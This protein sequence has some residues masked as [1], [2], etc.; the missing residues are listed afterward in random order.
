[1]ILNPVQA[2]ALAGEA[3]P[4][5]PRTRSKASEAWGLE[6]MYII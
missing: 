2:G 5:E 1:M 3:Q 4:T 6:A